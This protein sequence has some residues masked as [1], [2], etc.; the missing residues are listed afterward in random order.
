MV[1]L[2][3][4]VLDRRAVAALTLL[5]LWLKHSFQNPCRGDSAS[6][7]CHALWFGI[8]PT[9][10]PF[11]WE[12]GGR[13][14]HGNCRWPD[15]DSGW[16]RWTTN[17]LKQSSRFLVRAQTPVRSYFSGMFSSVAGR[18]VRFV[19]RQLYDRNLRSVGR[20]FSFCKYYY[21]RVVGAQKQIQA[22]I[23]NLAGTAAMSCSVLLIDRRWWCCLWMLLVVECGVPER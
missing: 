19:L 5:Q 16:R 8:R 21:W 2:L 11:L 22:R 1:Q 4:S 12:G 10:R 6:F 18:E 14:A 13:L 7:H 3:A 15:G 23:C 9:L 17:D 20:P